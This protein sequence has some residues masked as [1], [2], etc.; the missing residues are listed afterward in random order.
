MEANSEMLSKEQKKE[1]INKYKESKPSPGVYAVRCVPTAREWIGS[2]RNL[3][4][5]K[6][7]IWFSLRN[8]GHREKTLQD[9]WNG[10]GEMAFQYEILETLPDDTI[11]MAVSDLLR[12]KKKHW[13]A[14]RN[15][16][17]LL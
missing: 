5:T 14:V 16:H 17:A 8:R 9:E 7:G 6:N 12:E 4:A 2:S 13:I 15:A 1:A 3:G 11:P 10:H